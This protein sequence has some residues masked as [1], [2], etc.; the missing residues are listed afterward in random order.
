ME[1]NRTWQI[2]GAWL[3]DNAG[4]QSLFCYIVY[5]YIYI[6]VILVG[7]PIQHVG[8]TFLGP[9]SQLPQLPGKKPQ[10]FHVGY[11]STVRFTQSCC[12]CWWYC[13]LSWCPGKLVLFLFLFLLLLLLMLILLYILASRKA[14]CVVVV[15]DDDIVVHLQ[16]IILH[17]QLFFV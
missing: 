15:V 2:A 5:S 17:W 16:K 13:C 14:C 6:Y 10:L 7:S 1:F 11:V 3:Q 9:I 12:C 4:Y 8:C